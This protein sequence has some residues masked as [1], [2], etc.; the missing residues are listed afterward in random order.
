M[1]SSTL[2]IVVKSRPTG[3]MVP[4]ETFTS[5]TVPSP[6][7][8]DLEDGQLLVETLYLSLDPIMRRWLNAGNGIV[9]TTVG[10][11]MPGFVLGRVLASRS[12]DLAA[13][14]LVTAFSVWARAAVL[15]AGSFEKVDYLPASLPL[16]DVLGVLGLTGLTAYFG[17]LGIGKP[18]PGETVVVSSA[19]GATGSVAAQ[20]AKIRGARVVAI[21]GGEQ[22]GK[23]LR[24]LGVDEVLDYKDDAFEEKF[25][26]AVGGGIDLYFDSV[27]GRMLELALANINKFARIILNGDIS[28]YN[29]TTPH[30]IKS[31]F[32]IA[33]KS[34]TIH[35]L[36]IFDHLKDAAP[37]RAELGQWLQDGTL[38]R[39]QTVVEGGLEAAP[40]GLADLFTGKNT[41][42]MLVEV[43]GD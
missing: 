23:W 37:A 11:P 36:N 27:G 7:E 43:R 25:A 1:A 34:A 22:K 21:A 10:E 38:Q 5:G 9:K 31:I 3:A 26:K 15:P 6:T 20:L 2:Q 32:P 18:K 40:Q 28:G 24:G 19:A 42:K 39:T 17:M 16:T 13:G 35:G 33:P 30:G 14:D 4:G 8:Q 29:T 41:G 12:P